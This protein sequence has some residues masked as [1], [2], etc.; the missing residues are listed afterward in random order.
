MIYQNLIDQIKTESRLKDDDSFTSIAIG[1]LNEAFKE[2]VESQRPFELRN[3]VNLSLVSGVGTVSPPDDFFIHHQLFYKLSTGKEYQLTDQDKAIA[4]AP[5]GL[6]G[7]PKTFEIQEG[8][9]IVL[10]PVELISSGDNLRLIYY[11]IPPIITMANI[12]QENPIIRLEPFLIRFAIRRGRMFH[13]DDLQVAQM[14]TSDVGAAASA[15]TKDS[16]ERNSKTGA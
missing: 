3:E 10:S 6:Y 7:Y 8:L 13:S 15:Y 14:L 2:A 1:L 11:Q 12:T 4:P 9:N 5:R 16:P